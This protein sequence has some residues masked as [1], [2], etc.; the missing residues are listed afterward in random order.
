MLLA[1]HEFLVQR[2]ALLAE[3]AALGWIGREIPAHQTED[4]LATD[5]GLLRP[6]PQRPDSDDLT[7]ETC[8]Q[9]SEAPY[10]RTRTHQVRDDERLGPGPDQPMELRGQ[11]DPALAAAHA[12][13]AVDQD[14]PGGVGPGHA[15][16]QNEGAG[17]GG[18]D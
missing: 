2:H 4:L 10:G 13:G 5:L 16:G 9:L 11:G 17:T 12:L 18:E 6:A 8:H 7:S 3:R 1:L 14:R 15:V